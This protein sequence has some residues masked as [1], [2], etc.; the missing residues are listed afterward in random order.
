MSGARAGLLVP[1][2]APVDRRTS[3]LVVVIAIAA[4]LQTTLL[5]SIDASF[6]G[7]MPDHGHLYRNG[8]AVPHTH[9][10]DRARALPPQGQQACVSPPPWPSTRDVVFTPSADGFD[11]ASIAVPLL[12]AA[13][14]TPCDPSVTASQISTAPQPAAAD[15]WQ[16]VPT[17]PP[18]GSA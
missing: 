18:R 14:A 3:P 7:F 12:A 9:P 13:L 10:W 2:F 6:A 11:G 17:P 16:T 8:V 15:F 5:V 1:P 4:L